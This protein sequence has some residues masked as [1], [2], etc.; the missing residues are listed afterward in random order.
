MFLITSDNSSY[1]KGPLVF[2]IFF[3]LLVHIPCPFL[4]SILGLSRIS[5]YIKEL[6]LLC[7]ELQMFLLILFD[8]FDGAFCNQKIKYFFNVFDVVSIFC[9][10]DIEILKNAFPTPNFF[11]TAYVTTLKGSV[12]QQ[13]SKPNKTVTGV[14]TQKVRIY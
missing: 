9:L 7:S 12:C 1:I 11:T 5:W 6:S 10:W 2:F 14:C 3:E 8:V 4:S 13:A